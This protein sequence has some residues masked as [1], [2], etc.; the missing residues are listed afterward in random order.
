MA[1]INPTLLIIE[2]A[3]YNRHKDVLF[4]FKP[5][6]F[7]LS[8]PGHRQITTGKLASPRQYSKGPCGNRRMQFDGDNG[9]T[10][11]VYSDWSVEPS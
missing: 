9:E 7:R 6:D 3:E 4:M 8:H 1:K 2:V 10:Y 5:D 11:F